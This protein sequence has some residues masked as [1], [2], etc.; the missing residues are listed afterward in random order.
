MAKG[1]PVRDLVSQRKASCKVLF[2][3]LE[4]INRNAFYFFLLRGMFVS[5]NFLKAKKDLLSP[6]T[7]IENETFTQALTNAM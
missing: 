1:L 2:P 5:S 7:M 3:F 4:E 6:S